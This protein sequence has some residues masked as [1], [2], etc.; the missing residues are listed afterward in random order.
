M[1]KIITFLLTTLGLTTACGQQNF[2]NADVKAFAELTEDPAAVVLDVRT[3]E[4]FAEGHLEGAIN[5][6]QKQRLPCIAAA[7][8]VQPVLPVNWPTRATSA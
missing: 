4:E 6:D 2:E 7:A 1:K 3:P 5:I 8:A